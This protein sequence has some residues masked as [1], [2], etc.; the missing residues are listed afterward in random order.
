VRS[1]L[2][3]AEIGQSQE[4]LRLFL[5]PSKKRKPSASSLT[6]SLALH[7][8]TVAGLWTIQPHADI[9]VRPVAQAGAEPTSII[10]AQRLY[11]VTPLRRREVNRIE[12][13][14]A[15]SR[16]ERQR[17]AASAAPV[18]EPEPRPSIEREAAP[19]PK[20]P[21]PVAPR[22]FVPPQIWRDPT[23]SRVLIQPMSPPDLAPPDTNVPSLLVWTPRLARIPR[24]FV[25]PGQR[26]PVTQPTPSVAPPAPIDNLAVRPAPVDRFARLSLPALPPPPVME[27]PPVVMP[28][29][30]PLVEGDSVNI[31]SL[32]SRV[33]PIPDRIE[34]PAG[35]ITPPANAAATP[36]TGALAGSEASKA[37]KSMHS[38][39]SE[40]ANSSNGSASGSSISANTSAGTNTG[41]GKS[42]STGS[43][44]TGQSTSASNSPPASSGSSATGS[45]A[46][47][48]TL[49][50]TA[51]GAAANGT[52]GSGATRPVAGA[53][54][55]VPPMN[56][57]FDAVVVQSSAL[58]QFP[59]AK[60]LL[61]G[62]PIYTVYIPLGTAKDWAMSFCVLG[63]RA[64]AEPNGPVVNLA[65]SGP[66]VK[67]PYPLQ[68]LRPAISIPSYQRYVLIYGVIG[69]RGEVNEL[70]VVQPSRLQASAVLIDTLSQWTFRPATVDGVPVP[71]EFVL[72]IPQAGL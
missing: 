65:A 1:S 59:D 12:K 30:A 60:H 49:G 17:P 67:P 68:M 22:A 21:E 48:R 56:G 69:N 13:A 47:T 62:R 14:I 24:K 37:N 31:L 8:V 35:N 45:D 61:K 26:D 46:M 16:S 5:F 27:T 70:R 15:E 72:A 42:V 50:A 10:I 2:V 29:P 20:L 66:A 53:M 28:A 3:L 11:Y 54:I 55:V 40:G 52:A 32:N 39:G 7:V 43:S 6:A 4:E 23:I 19:A 57:T 41:N 18:H 64:A 34:V 33:Q 51:G 25:S 9:P 71:V 63:E 58:D 44:G 36:I 38:A